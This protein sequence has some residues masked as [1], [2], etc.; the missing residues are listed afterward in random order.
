M[1]K[2]EK[3]ELQ[4]FRC[5]SK[6][7]LSFDAETTVI[8]AE[9]GCGKTSVF[10]SVR[11]LLWLLLAQF[12][13]VPTQRPTRENLR[14]FPFALN[15]V[16]EA[17]TRI[18]FPTAAF[19]ILRAYA[20]LDFGLS[21]LPMPSV[22]WDFTL[23]RD[24]ATIPE[25]GVRLAQLMDAMKPLLMASAEGQFPQDGYP[26]FAAFGTSR[27]VIRQVPKSRRG[28][29]KAFSRWDAYRG[30]LNGELDYRRLVEW[31]AWLD[32]AALREMKAR[33]DV[34]Y[35]SL[36]QR[37]IDLALK[38]MLPEF[39]N[40]RSALRPLRLLVDRKIGDVS[41]T[42]RIDSQLSDGY[43]SMLTLGL[44]IVSRSLEANYGWPEATPE[45]I[46]AVPGIVLIDEVDLHLHPAWQKRV[47]QDLRNTFPNIQ[48]IV[49]THSPHVVASVKPSQLR[50]LQNLNKQTLDVTLAPACELPVDASD[51]NSVLAHVFGVDPWPPQ[52]DV[53]AKLNRFGILTA[54][55][56]KLSQAGRDEWAALRDELKQIY[57]ADF[58]PLKALLDYHERKTHR[59][60]FGHADA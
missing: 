28:F 54:S 43:K 37:T 55:Y 53:T 19:L 51:T 22:E 27:A 29:R 34:D 48:F 8:V 39:S 15:F 52:G 14:V 6:F 13:Q 7:E 42:Y 33:R 47:L 41:Q 31:V 9:N 21:E 32:D 16:R 40:L 17:E 58:A 2:I 59:K 30:A 20:Q 35:R 26:V 11:Y 25:K 49:T 3:I 38:R 44:S 60:G 23:R 56:D 1:V 10:D 24:K 12:P 18:A 46:L 5:F 45:R 57:P 36:E 50:I 4:N